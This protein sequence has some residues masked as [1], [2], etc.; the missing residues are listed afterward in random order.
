MYSREHPDL[1]GERTDV[2]RATTID[3]S[4]V[5]DDPGPNDLFGQ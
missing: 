4:P 5:V 1:S 3:A 2:S